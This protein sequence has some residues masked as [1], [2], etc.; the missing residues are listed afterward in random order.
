MWH[1][2]VV[3]LFDEE[4]A[5]SKRY[6]LCD[7]FLIIKSFDIFWSFGVADFAF[8]ICFYL[9]FSRAPI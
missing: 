7:S 5:C 9:F 2:S 4:P 1:I 3:N 8:L 6:I